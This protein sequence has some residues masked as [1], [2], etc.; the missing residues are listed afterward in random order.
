M[1]RVDNYKRFSYL[2]YLHTMCTPPVLNKDRNWL[3][4]MCSLAGFTQNMI[5]VCVRLALA[6]FQRKKAKINLLL[7]VGVIHLSKLWPEV[8]I[9]TSQIWNDKLGEYC[10]SQRRNVC[11]C[12]E[13]IPVIRAHSTNSIYHNQDYIN[14]CLNMP[15]LWAVSFLCML[16]IL[17]SLKSH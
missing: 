6:S 10:Y 15:Q 11:M 9:I 3:K 5:C 14:F 17:M 13:I 7:S 8:H 4:Q 16:H 12:I 2:R 1:I